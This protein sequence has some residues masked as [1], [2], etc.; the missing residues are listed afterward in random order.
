M[1]AIGAKIFF[2]KSK[3]DGFIAQRSNEA[4]N[5]LSN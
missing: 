1:S 2:G 5:S 3:G 4:S